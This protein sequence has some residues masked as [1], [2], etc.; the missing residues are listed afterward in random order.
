MDRRRRPAESHQ[1]LDGEAETYRRVTPWRGC[2][3][4]VS[5]IESVVQKTLQR[6]AS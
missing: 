5:L 6:E 1:P 2:S 4:V 3:D